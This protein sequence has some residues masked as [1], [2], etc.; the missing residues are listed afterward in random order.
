MTKKEKAAYKMGLRDSAAMLR[1]FIMPSCTVSWHENTTVGTREL[2]SIY[3]EIALKIET[4][5]PGFFSEE[6]FAR[7]EK[8]KNA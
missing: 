4:L 2:N 6:Y 7:K 8:L 1:L 5:E 3:A